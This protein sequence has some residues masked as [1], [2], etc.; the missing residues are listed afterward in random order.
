MSTQEVINVSNNHNPV[1]RAPAVGSQVPDDVMM[2]EDA[3]IVSI[4]MGSEEAVVENSEQEN[5]NALALSTRDESSD[6]SLGDK[7]QITAELKESINEN[8]PNAFGK[9]GP[10]HVEVTPASIIELLPTESNNIGVM[11]NSQVPVDNRPSTITINNQDPAFLRV[12]Q[13]IKKS[14]VESIVM[15]SIELSNQGEMCNQ[16]NTPNTSNTVL[17]AEPKDVEN[18]FEMI[19]T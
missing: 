11:S 8:R 10:T 2:L 4:I 7:V 3:A 15:D 1:L 16:P 6:L 17:D 9:A 19:S 14:E 12:E 13:L 5:N 18:Q